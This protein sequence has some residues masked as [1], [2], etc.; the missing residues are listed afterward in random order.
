MSYI[1][2]SNMLYSPL[3]LKVFDY[4][5]LQITPSQNRRGI[6]LRMTFFFFFIDTMNERLKYD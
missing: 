6:V 1:P 4:I 3:L 5:K 2:F